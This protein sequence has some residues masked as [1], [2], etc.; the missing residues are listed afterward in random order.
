MSKDSSFLCLP[1]IAFFVKKH[2]GTFSQ[3]LGSKIRTFIRQIPSYLNTKK[4]SFFRP[5]AL[6]NN[7]HPDWSTTLPEFFATWT[8]K[9]LPLRD[10]SLILLA[11]LPL[12]C[13]A[14]LSGKTCR[15]NISAEQS[16]YE[17][18]EQYVSHYWIESFDNV[19]TVHYLLRSDT[20]HR[21]TEHKFSFRC[22]TV[23]RAAQI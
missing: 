7:S 8:S 5:W 15:K 21:L 17:V 2:G 13:S 20:R 22:K 3:P 18:R 12:K 14:S 10:S 9:V 23:S 19:I 11:I 6:I 1:L 4:S 16:A